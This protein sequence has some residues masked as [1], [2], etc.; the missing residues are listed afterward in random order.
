MCT[1]I[2]KKFDDLPK[3]EKIYARTVVPTF[4]AWTTYLLIGIPVGP[5]WGFM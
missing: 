2:I 5:L 1:E 3:E 4:I